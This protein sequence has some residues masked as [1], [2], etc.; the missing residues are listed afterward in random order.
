M[1]DLPAGTI[2]LLFTDIEG[3]TRLWEAQSEAMATA[4]ARHDFVMRRCIEERHGH[5]FKTVGDAFFAAFHTAPD[6]LAAALDAQRAMHRE[7]WPEGAVLRVRMALHSGA[8]ETRDGDYFGAPLNR[9]ARLLAA[10]HGG[11]T[12]LSAIAYDLCR[13]RLP[14]D[15]IVR[16]LGLHGLKDLGRVETLYQVSDRDLPQAFPPLRTALAPL[17]RASPS[18]AV[19]PFVNMSRDEENEFFA[20]GLAEEL[21]NLLAKIRNLRV[22]SRTSAFS[23]KGK[24]VDIGT[25]ARKLNVAT[26][27]EGSVRKAGKRVRI[28]AQLIE[29]ATDSHLW[30]QT[31]DRDLDDIFAVQDDIAQAVVTELREA[32]MGQPAEAAAGTAAA[33]VRAAATGRSENPE[34]FQL[35]LQAKFAGERITRES[36]DRAIA[37][38]QRAIEVEP[39]F[40]LA[41]AELANMHQTQAGFAFAPIEEGIAKARQAAL[42]SLEI[43]PDLAEGHLALGF[44][45]QSHDWD[46]EAAGASLQRA[47]ELAPSDA[48]ALRGSAVHAHIIGRVDDAV[49]LIRRAVALDPL[50]PRVHR[51]AALIAMM[52]GRL[53]EAAASVQMAIDLAPNAGMAHGLFSIV[54]LL[55]YRLDEA[56][57]LAKAE[58]HLVFRNAA[59]AI[60]CQRLALP[61]EAEAALRH[62]L[63]DFPDTA[64]FQIAEIYATRDDLDTAFRW[65]DRAY[66]LRDS[67]LMFVATDPH[68]RSLHR[69]PRWG[70]LL[71]RMN[72]R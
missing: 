46:W 72:L 60:I 33:V 49:E 38:F 11:Q 22:A 63:D 40:A 37:L 28:T 21:L 41:W 26:I 19:L 58:S 39:T 47:L 15:A 70:T 5:V 16:P 69:D 10:G 68:L 29:V 31:Y 62:L 45:L 61:T 57:T 27:L 71:D 1:A 32:L 64:A 53:D 50:S 54:R 17:A 44:I 42:R 24:D 34:A 7:S 56:L 3:S 23:F 66:E 20:D 2:T 8:V 13:D 65:L 52:A 25:V 48:S 9:V 30:S 35:F 36:T 51:Q 59:L 18:I 67:G 6:A 55:Q 12:L 4:L 14:V 43:A